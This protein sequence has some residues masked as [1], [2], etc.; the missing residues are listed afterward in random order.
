[1]LDLYVS[2]HIDDAIL[3]CAGMMCQNGNDILIVNIFTKPVEGTKS[4]HGSELDLQERRNEEELVLDQFKKIIG[5]KNIEIIYLDYN[6]A[7]DR[8]FQLKEIL[9]PHDE[10]IF[11]SCDIEEIEEKI[12]GILKDRNPDRI[13]VPTGTGNHVDH[14]LT[15][16]I[17]HRLKKKLSNQEILFYSD[18]PYTFSA[19]ISLW[20][21]ALRLLN[22][23]LWLRK[24]HKIYHINMFFL[25]LKIK[26]SQNQNLPLP[27]KGKE[28]PIDITDVIDKKIQLCQLYKNQLRVLF[29]NDPL[30]EKF[31]RKFSVE[32]IYQ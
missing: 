10:K 18:I 17:G 4:L 11:G 22:P 28:N 14:V 27:Q 6:D 15:Y 7:L 1:M 21:T 9:G 26:Q 16:L 3:S 25:H 30:T 19:K 2:P 29:G 23:I 32:L 12:N 8:G 20:G 5:N 24:A 31:F 13:F